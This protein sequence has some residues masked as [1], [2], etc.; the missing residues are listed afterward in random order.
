MPKKLCNQIGCS[1]IIKFEDRYCSDHTRTNDKA[2]SSKYYDQ[3]KRDKSRSKFY[4]SAQW[5]KLRKVHL[6]I[7]PLCVICQVPGEIVDH[8]IEIK[9]GGC[10]TCLDNLQTLCQPC[11]NTKTA[12]AARSRR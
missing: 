10:A 11:H 9:D 4:H 8:K 12:Q 2:K 1:N 3:N 7:Q 5:K 6:D